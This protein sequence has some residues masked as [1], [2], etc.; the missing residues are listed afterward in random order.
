MLELTESL[1]KKEPE[2]LARKFIECGKRDGGITSTQIR[3]FYDDLLLIQKKA[4]MQ[5]EESFKNKTLPLVRMTEAKIAYSVGRGVLNKLFYDEIS[6]YLKKIQSKEDLEIFN[7]FYQAL[8]AYVKYEE[9]LKKKDEKTNYN[10][11]PYKHNDSYGNN[12]NW[13]GFRK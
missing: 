6:K 5:D 10:N 8:I 4:K 3:K 11:K 12:N 13:G 2:E 1:L 9:T 7:L